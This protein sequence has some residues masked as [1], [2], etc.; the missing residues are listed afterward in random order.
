MAAENGP[1]AG[2]REPSGPLRFSAQRAGVT[3]PSRSNP[4]QTRTPLVTSQ[5][6]RPLGEGHL[7][8]RQASWRRRQASWSIQEASTVATLQEVRGPAD[9]RQDSWT[10][11]WR[12]ELL[13][14]V[15]NRV[16]LPMGRT[17]GQSTW[18]VI[19]DTNYLVMAPFVPVH[20]PSCSE[21]TSSASKPQGDIE[22]AATPPLL[23]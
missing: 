12:T 4:D 3:C 20:C 10:R 7:T 13:D 22:P 17:M 19:G 6:D 21:P 14:G 23:A 5:G 15:W 18:N 11:H 9:V 1:R 16:G 8:R 2:T